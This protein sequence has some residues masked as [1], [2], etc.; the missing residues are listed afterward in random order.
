MPSAAQ[1]LIPNIVVVRWYSETA[2]YKHVLSCKSSW[3]FTI[4]RLRSCQW[5]SDFTLRAPEYVQG[6]LAHNDI[7]TTIRKYKTTS[8]TLLSYCAS[9]VCGDMYSD[10]VMV[11][12][13]VSCTLQRCSLLGPTR[14]SS[15]SDEVRR[16]L[17][18]PFGEWFTD[19]MYA[20]RSS[21]M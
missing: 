15:K 12:R 13:A 18:R 9:W 5:A 3:G 21:R 8:R 14:T 6:L 4:V 10:Q 1:R 7:S 11:G 2:A 17:R 20:K 16:F 19:R